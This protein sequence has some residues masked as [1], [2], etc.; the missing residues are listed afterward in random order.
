MLA[1]QPDTFISVLII[2]E[3]KNSAIGIHFLEA[4]GGTSLLKESQFRI[5]RKC[6]G[7]FDCLVYEMLLIKFKHTNWLHPC[8]TFYMKEHSNTSI[9]YVIVLLFYLGPVHTN[10]FSKTSVFCFLKT[11]RSIYVHISI[12]T[13]FSTVH[14]KPPNPSSSPVFARLYFLCTWHAWT[15]IAVP[16]GTCKWAVT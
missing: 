1:T 7:K 15:E 9:P 13:A 10:A 11:H 2:V 14:T 16:A 6:Q 3:H 8:E 4:H 5:L 12:F